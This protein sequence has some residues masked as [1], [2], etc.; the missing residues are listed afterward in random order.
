[1]DCFAID[2]IDLAPMGFAGS[3]LG[4]YYHES[5][6]RFHT[7][8]PREFTLRSR[9]VSITVVEYLLDRNRKGME[10]LVVKMIEK[11]WCFS[12]KNLVN[13]R[14]AS[15]LGCDFKYVYFHSYLGKI[16]GL[17]N[18]F[19]DGLNPLTRQSHNIFR[20]MV[21]FGDE[22]WIDLLYN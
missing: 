11:R 1:M 15:Q 20:D 7:L 6:I 10:R 22:T 5:L 17:A 16:P 2:K 4:V 12:I 21:G 19:S 9:C 14:D 13:I 18:I 3:L 8:F